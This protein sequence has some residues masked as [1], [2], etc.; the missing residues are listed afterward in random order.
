[1]LMI[2]LFLCFFLWPYMIQLLP[3]MANVSDVFHHFCQSQVQSTPHAATNLALLCGQGM[4]FEE[5]RERIVGVG[6]YHFILFSG[7]HLVFLEHRFARTFPKKRALLPAM[8]L[9]FALMSGWPGRVVRTWVRTLL[10]APSVSPRS[11]LIS[12]W[13]LCLF[14]HPQWIHSLSLHLSTAAGLVFLNEKGSFLRASFKVFLILSPLFAGWAP[15]H[16][17]IP[18]L[19]AVLVPFASVLWVT[20]ALVEFV[21]PRGWFV[22]NRADDL[23]QR[24]LVEAEA[25]HPPFE[26]IKFDASSW[27]WAYV[28]LL[29][30]VTHGWDVSEKRKKQRALR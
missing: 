12:S 28:L 22:L 1:M 9:V 5:I 8:L 2:S 14:W 4:E 11:S 21:D 24:V 26:K 3:F 29:F 6:L 19:G 7:L 20:E 13:L 25:L 18:V 17:F 23:F 30:V 15:L 10:R 16:P 27:G